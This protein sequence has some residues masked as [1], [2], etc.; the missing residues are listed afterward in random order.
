M[1]EALEIPSVKDA[2]ER[3]WLA[4]SDSP[5]SFKVS[6]GMLQALDSVAVRAGDHFKLQFNV[7]ASV[8]EWW[9]HKKQGSRKLKSVTKKGCKLES[10]SLRDLVDVCFW[11]RQ[12][13][14]QV[15]RARLNGQ[16]VVVKQLSGSIV[17]YVLGFAPKENVQA[18]HHE[19]GTHHTKQEKKQWKKLTFQDEAARARLGYQSC[20]TS[21]EP[22]G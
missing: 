4:W 1:E 7:F 15:H 5:S 10:V 6:Q 17:H 19:D 11:R 2:K 9:R 21:S 12:T 14:L 16:E 13:K 20:P 3:G 18:D 8:E 22:E